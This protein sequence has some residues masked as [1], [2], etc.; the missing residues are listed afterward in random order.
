MHS[1][2]AFVDEVRAIAGILAEGGC[3]RLTKKA[4][5][6]LRKRCQAWLDNAPVT[7]SVELQ[8]RWGVVVSGL[9]RA[10]D[11][12]LSGVSSIQAP[13]A[14]E[15]L[16][17][18]LNWISFKT[19]EQLFAAS[20]G[21]QA[22]YASVCSCA[23]ALRNAPGY[24]MT[25]HTALSEHRW[26][27]VPLLGLLGWCRDAHRGYRQTS[28][29]T[30]A[31]WPED[32]WVEAIL[33]VVRYTSWDVP[34]H[35]AFHSLWATLAVYAAPI[36]GKS[37]SRK[38]L[39]L[40]WNGHEAAMEK[41]VIKLATCLPESA[42]DAL[43]FAQAHPELLTST[44]FEA[45]AQL[46]IRKTS[47]RHPQ[48][49]CHG[50]PLRVAANARATGTGERANRTA[51]GPAISANGRNASFV[52]TNGARGTRNFVCH[53]TFAGVET[54]GAGA[55]AGN[56]GR[57]FGRLRWRFVLGI[58][59]C[60]GGNDWLFLNTLGY[61][62]CMP[63]L[64]N[65]LQRIKAPFTPDPVVLD[66]HAVALFSQAAR[67]P[68]HDAHEQTWI[69]QFLS[70][71]RDVQARKAEKTWLYAVE[72]NDF[73]LD[74][75]DAVIGSLRTALV[76]DMVEPLGKPRVLNARLLWSQFVCDAIVE[77]QWDISRWR[78]KNRWFSVV[79]LQAWDSGNE[80][81]LAYQDYI[82]NMGTWHLWARDA[83]LEHRALYIRSTD[84][85]DAMFAG[86][87]TTSLSFV[88]ALATICL[89]M[90]QGAPTVG[91]SRLH[92]QAHASW[93]AE[94]AQL[95]ATMRAQ[96]MMDGTRLEDTARIAK[97]MELGEKGYSAYFSVFGESV[98]ALIGHHLGRSLDV[99]E[100]PLLD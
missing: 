66:A 2:K 9:V 82:E 89:R 48:D 85:L 11:I 21:R 25:L 98:H 78:N 95:E 45:I 16:I 35:P 10:E 87:S 83:L 18:W 3:Q 55:S 36:P 1:Y 90:H 60:R 33:G 61:S 20:R 14:A 67:A 69:G 28:K 27:A 50:R 93:P 41:L 13:R 74:A 96:A 77:Q 49:I 92:R 84:T 26:N 65:V 7:A 47:A 37:N 52:R 79:L 63:W 71:M 15:E 76:V 39:V 62:E 70:R 86:P 56:N 46:D 12:L 80:K 44:A 68:G 24:S 53:D 88:T 73:L 32:N 23:Q 34:A 58:T 6:P 97:S 59:P 75:T 72:G 30:G 100:L 57:H 38:Q 99:L 51:L 17:D 40:H 22:L 43:L 31:M 42:A 64:D 4:A 8:R 91:L 81:R 54:F 5:R 19:P 94:M 29:S